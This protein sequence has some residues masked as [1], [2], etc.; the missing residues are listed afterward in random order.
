MVHAV[1]QKSKVRRTEVI[2]KLA[3]QVGHTISMEILPS[4]VV[5]S[6]VGVLHNSLFA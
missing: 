1:T 2:F 3:C 6:F 5:I 4:R